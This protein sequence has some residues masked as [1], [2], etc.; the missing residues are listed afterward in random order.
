MLRRAEAQASGGVEL[1]PTLVVV[2]LEAD[3]PGCELH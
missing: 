2:A 3:A 1:A